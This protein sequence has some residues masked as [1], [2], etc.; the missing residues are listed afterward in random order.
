[1]AKQRNQNPHDHGK[2]VS[3]ARLANAKKVQRAPINAQPSCALET[4]RARFEQK[5]RFRILSANGAQVAIQP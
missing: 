5:I 3:K 1:M 4:V 2:A